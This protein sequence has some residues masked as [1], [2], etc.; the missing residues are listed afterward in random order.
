VPEKYHSWLYAIDVD[1]RRRI[2]TWSGTEPTGSFFPSIHFESFQLGVC[3][4]NGEHK[5][6]R[7]FGKMW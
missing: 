1:E 3:R 2:I 7:D 5:K 6:W 4:Q